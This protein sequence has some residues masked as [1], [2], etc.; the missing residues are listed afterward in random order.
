M[1]EGQVPSGVALAVQYGEL[2]EAQGPA[3]TDPRGSDSAEEE[4]SD[5]A[6]GDGGDD[7][8]GAHPGATPTVAESSS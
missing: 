6:A 5:V 1:F 4:C 3:R 2:L 8:D 7:D